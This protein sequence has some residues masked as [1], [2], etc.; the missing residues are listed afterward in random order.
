MATNKSLRN[1]LDTIAIKIAAVLQN[2]KI[3]FDAMLD[4][5]KALTAYHLGL[6]KKGDKQ[7]E[8]G[9]GTTT[10]FDQLRALAEGKTQ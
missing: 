7:A 4:G 1:E 10:T 9:P 2:E 3:P 8:D 6:L 5:F